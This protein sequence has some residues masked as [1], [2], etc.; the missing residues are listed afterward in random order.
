MSW[1]HDVNNVQYVIDSVQRQNKS[2]SKKVTGATRWSNS[3]VPRVTQLD[4]LSTQAD[5]RSLLTESLARVFSVAPLTS[6]PY[7]YQEELHLAL[8]L[9]LFRYS[10][11]RLGASVGDRLHNLV[12]R[13]ELAARAYGKEHVSH[14]VPLFCPPRR[15]LI[16][17][18]ILELLVPYLWRKLQRKA[19][20]ENWATDEESSWRSK[21]MKALQYTLIAWST[22][23]LLNTIHFLTTG[24]YRTLVERMLGLH[25]VNGSQQVMRLTNLMYLNQIITSQA[26]QSLLDVFEIGN[27]IKKITRTAYAFGTPREVAPENRCCACYE[28][29]TIS[30]RSN[31]GHLYCYY[32]I[33]SRLLQCEAEGSFPCLRCGKRVSSCE[34]DQP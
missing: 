18:G 24:Q 20:E 27:I 7:T 17:Y 13:D 14:L 12:V 31:C 15:L 19:F 33:R 22:M 29:P 21:F 11:Y 16:L 34:P 4:A 10:T 5:L 6:V 32:C 3:K 30:Q 25:M 1:I 8:D 23:S 28:L 9:V 26:F 2:V